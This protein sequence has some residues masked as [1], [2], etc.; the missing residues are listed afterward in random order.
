MR[1][2]QKKECS[3]R[4][5]EGRYIFNDCKCLTMQ[6]IVVIFCWSCFINLNYHEC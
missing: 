6:A 5:A 2:G 1:G 3:Q 4:E